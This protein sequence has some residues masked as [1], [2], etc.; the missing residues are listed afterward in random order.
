MSATESSQCWDT[1]DQGTLAELS[2]DVIAWYTDKYSK[3]DSVPD[4]IDSRDIQ[5]ISKNSAHFLNKIIS[6]YL[7]TL[8]NNKQPVIGDLTIRIDQTLEFRKEF[9]VN[10][11]TSACISED[12][13]RNGMCYSHGHDIKGNPII[14]VQMNKYKRETDYIVA[15]KIFVC[16]LMEQHSL[17]YPQLL[18]TVLVDCTGVGMAQIDF[19]FARFLLNIFFKHYPLRL[20][21][22]LLYNIPWVLMSSWNV[23]R[24]WLPAY[25]AH[26]T[27]VVQTNQITK[28]IPPDQLLSSFPGGLNE[29]R[30]TYPFSSDSVSS[31]LNQVLINFMP[32]NNITI[33]DELQYEESIS[34]ANAFEV[35]IRHRDEHFVND[36][37]LLEALSSNNGLT[38]DENFDDIT[39]NAEESSKVFNSFAPH[40]QSPVASQV[41]PNS[42]IKSMP[43]LFLSP[44]DC[45]LVFT[46]DKF[47]RNYTCILSI[48]NNHPKLCI[49][50][51]VKSTRVTNYIV[52][53]IL[54]ILPP[55]HSIDIKITLAFNLPFT[56]TT[57]RFLIMA[58]VFKEHYD[59]TTSTDIPQESVIQFWKDINSKKIVKYVYKCQHDLDSINKTMQRIQNAK[60]YDN[61]SKPTDNAKLTQI[62]SSEKRAILKRFYSILPNHDNNPFARSDHNF[63]EQIKAKTLMNSLEKANKQERNLKCII[64]IVIVSIIFTILRYILR[65]K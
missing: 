14:Y 51:K 12:V 29:W 56:S 9:K 37:S 36:S 8:G 20:S 47:S 39:K 3:S 38:K 6:Q 19:D 5:R 54:G 50:F 57:D 4:T 16:Y 23:C 49:A 26:I 22:I 58:A 65:S 61:I 24:R 41:L 60:K 45:S 10:D 32:V 2:G 27:H 18:L 40:C 11:L 25:A 48:L 52:S 46:Y 55:V 44:K 33:D 21:C 63:N 53:P 34:D 62:S 17:L 64:I 7:I 35:S 42:Y 13:L 43:Y 59:S 30:Y 1:V 15:F 28:H 31:S